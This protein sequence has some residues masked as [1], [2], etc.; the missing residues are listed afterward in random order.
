MAPAVQLVVG[1]LG[2]GRLVALEYYLLRLRNLAVDL[3]V[4]GVRLARVEVGPVATASVVAAVVG[5]VAVAVVTA[6]AVAVVVV[7]AVAVA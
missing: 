4:G 3:H 6:V 5:A 2:C 7:V 1:L